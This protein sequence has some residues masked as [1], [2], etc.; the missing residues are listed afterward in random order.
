MNNFKRPQFFR[1]VSAI[2]LVLVV[3][4]LGLLAALA[5][6]KLSRAGEFSTE[7]ALRER[8]MVLR[9]AIDLYHRDHGVYPCATPN[10]I[11]ISDD[12]CS[13][14]DAN[15]KNHPQAAIQDC[16]GA[17]L[18]KHTSIKGETSEN[19]IGP[20]S[21]GPYLRGSIPKSPLSNASGSSAKILVIR[22]ST[23]PAYQ[24][25]FPQADWVFNCD[26]GDIAV[27]S[28]QQDSSGKRFDR[29]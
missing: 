12:G 23:P 1:A 10:E 29:Y 8:L 4:I 14:S 3:I 21:F 25:N 7:S 19:R 9:T 11:E 26:T 2:E 28:D 24:E 13:A 15:E 18:T 22:G 17:Q 6:P 16:F 27:N 20:F 5:I